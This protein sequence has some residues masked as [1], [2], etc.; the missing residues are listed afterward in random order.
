MKKQKNME[1]IVYIQEEFVLELQSSRF[2]IGKLVKAISRNRYCM[3]RWEYVN[4]YL[5][6]EYWNRDAILD[7]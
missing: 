5:K 2:R 3:R 1:S 6:R 7:E 4:K